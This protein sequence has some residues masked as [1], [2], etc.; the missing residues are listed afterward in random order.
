[1]L[2][3]RINFNGILDFHKSKKL[4]RETKSSLYF[5]RRQTRSRMIFPRAHIHI[6]PSFHQ[7]VKSIVFRRPQIAFAPFM[8]VYIIKIKLNAFMRASIRLFSNKQIQRHQP[9]TEPHSE[10]ESLRVTLFELCEI[11]YYFCLIYLGILPA[12]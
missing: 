2:L 12:I 5:V 7:S 11:Q 3:I 9:G 1:M 10:A 8:H 6:F 4:F